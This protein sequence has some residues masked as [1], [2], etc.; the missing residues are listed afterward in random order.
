MEHEK[1]F[2]ELTSLPP[3]GRRQVA[4]FISS[5]RKRYA[6]ASAPKKA[7]RLPLRS[8]KFIGMWKDRE[9]LTDSTAWVRSVRKNEWM[10]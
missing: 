3:E 9:D 7:K 5:L 2:R 1:L 10:N 6:R 8:E 4:K